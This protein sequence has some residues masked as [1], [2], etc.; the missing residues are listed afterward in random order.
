MM[1]C[2]AL[3]TSAIVKRRKTLLKNG[4]QPKRVLENAVDVLR[5]PPPP[6]VHLHHRTLAVVVGR[7]NELDRARVEEV[8]VGHQ[9]L[10]GRSS[11]DRRIVVARL[12]ANESEGTIVDQVIDEKPR[13]IGDDVKFSY[14][15]SV[16]R[17]SRTLSKI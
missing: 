5:R 10:G 4:H 8:V 16:F 17:Q 2:D 3:K 13:L 9:F 1:K 15:F 14:F 7:E 11:R 6:R 12:P